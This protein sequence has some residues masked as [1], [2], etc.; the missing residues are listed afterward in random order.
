MSA[1]Q[2][3]APAARGGDDVRPT[4]N[5][6]DESAGGRRILNSILHRSAGGAAGES[7]PPR[8]AQSVGKLLAQSLARARERG[9]AAAAGA[10]GEGGAGGDGGRAEAGPFAAR[11]PERSSVDTSAFLRLR[12]ALSPRGGSAR[13]AA[14]RARVRETE[15][16][17]AAAAATSSGGADPAD[18]RPLGGGSAGTGSPEAW[19]ALGPAPEGGGAA[20]SLLPFSA[21]AAA[22]AA[23][24]PAGAGVYAGAAMPGGGVS[25]AD[26][27]LDYTRDSRQLAEEQA[28]LRMA[29]AGYKPTSASERAAFAAQIKSLNA[30]VKDLA[31]E[32]QKRRGLDADAE[33]KAHRR[34]RVSIS[35]PVPVPFLA[36]ALGVSL[37][38]VLDHLEAVGEDLAALSAAARELGEVAVTVD[39]DVAEFVVKELGGEAV[40]TDFRDR[41]P[42]P[43]PSAEEA[44]DAA[45]PRRVPVVTVMGHVDHG[46]TT[47]LDY[48][49]HAAVAESEAGGIT[50]GISAFCVRVDEAQGVNEAARAKKGG[51][52]SGKGGSS[53]KAKG[54]KGA[55]GLTSAVEQA[56]TDP[57]GCLT[58]LDTPGHQLFSGMRQRGTAVTDA[59]VLVVA[60]EDGVM[61]QTA[62]CVELLGRLPEVPVVVAV[63]KVDR[64]DESETLNAMDAIAEQLAA[65]GMTTE[66]LGGHVPIVGVSGVTGAGVAELKEHLVLQCDVLELRADTAGL[67][68]AAVL[69]SRLDRGMGYVADCVVQWGTL[70]VGDAVVVGTVRGRVKGLV[71]DAGARHKEMP[72]GLPVRV[73]GLQEPPPAGELLMAVESEARAQ[74]VVE[75]RQRVA[76]LA[77]AMERAR[78]AAALAVRFAEQRREEK[79]RKDREQQL[80]RRAANRRRLLSAGEPIP[81]P[82][83]LQ[84]WEVSLKARLLEEAE[85]AAD[86]IVVKRDSVMVARGHQQL[87]QR[88]DDDAPTLPIVLRSDMRGSAE[89]LR[90]AIESFPQSGL[91]LRVVKDDVGPPSMADFEFVRDT[92]S[93]L[94][95]FNVGVPSDVQRRAEQEGVELVRGNVIYAVLQATAD[96]I[97]K[98][99]PLVPQE[100]VGGVAEVLSTFQITTRR[101]D[102][103]LAAGCRVTNGV[104]ET[105]TRMRVMRGGETVF[106]AE[107]ITTLKRFRDDVTRVE[108]GLEC[109]ISFA[110]FS[111]FELGDK[112][113]CIRSEMVRQK[114]DISYLG[115]GFGQAASVRSE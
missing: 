68:E 35:G 85:M 48:L 100:V 30:T 12:E 69:D 75:R 2:R 108:K 70:K 26:D 99:L 24:G 64:L 88:G 58:F 106:E 22:A 50:Q 52:K 86:G 51:T 65:I 33:P 21:S 111:D 110:E 4:G 109:G 13:A 76:E 34:P 10:A 11:P 25:A 41:V 43:R 57:S 42:A 60:A 37:S 93:L 31:R 45:L 73:V 61:P 101:S 49:R 82:L 20:S 98:L 14:A 81:P 107:A 38:A 36:K 114:L 16:R 32:V 3:H 56:K 46:K 79:D 19:A 18:V 84:E 53:R 28:R 80:H 74:E 17:H 103:E 39:A 7:A 104:V 8:G 91:Q 40:R 94:V 90:A 6:D 87:V 89:A 67:G 95:A 27:M 78:D 54:G 92:G 29:L 71:D 15:S 112:I 47:L 44:E 59:V 96:R 5:P 77:E 97:S 105:G 66:P 9:Q 115:A 23:G 55:A 102:A 62:E 1:R 113:L 63:T 83:E 72:A